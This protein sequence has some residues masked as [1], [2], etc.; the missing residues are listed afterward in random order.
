MSIVS[1]SHSL[2]AVLITGVGPNGLGAALAE[3]LASQDP[4]LLILTGR[5]L[6]KVEIT[7]KDI[8]TKYPSVNIR[9][10]ELDL[11]SFKSIDAAAAA[12]NAYLESSIDILINNAGVMNI[13]ERTLSTDGFEM[14]LAVNYLGAFRF[15]NSIMGKLLVRG[16]RVVNVGSSGYA[17]SPFRFA[18]YNFA[19]KPLPESEQPSEALC[20]AFGL[21]WGLGYLP[22]IAYCQSKTAMMLYSVQLSKLLSAKGVTAVCTNPGGK[23]F[24]A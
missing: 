23:D 13:P 17:L 24:R 20:K 2:H 4:A 11:A 19:D 21:P 9:L 8:A 10:L 7:S 12:V 15:T 5:T 14:H 6:S 18:D 16:G 22:T 1:Y 3:S